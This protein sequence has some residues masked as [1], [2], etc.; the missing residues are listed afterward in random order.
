M[1]R[2]MHV[3]RVVCV[4]IVVLVLC[5]LDA[6]AQVTAKPHQLRLV[7]QTPFV[8]PSGTF[9]VQVDTGDLPT[10]TGLR[11][12]IYTEVTSRS[13]LDRTIAGEQLGSALFSTPKTAVGGTLPT[14]LS[15]PTAEQWPAPSGGTVLS[16]SGVYPVLI[17]ATDSKGATVDSIVT[18]LVRLPAITTATTPL[19]L[20]ATVTID[21]PLS[22]AD[23]GT[24]S[25]TAEHRTRA[26]EQF[27]VLSEASA[28]PL[29]LAAT[30]FLIQTLAETG[31]P[32]IRRPA[33]ERQTLS[34][35]FV[36][37]D[38]GSLEAAGR[39]TTIT[40]EYA[41]GD[42]VLS[43]IFES[44]PD[45]RILVLDSSV[46]PAALSRL[47]QLGTQAVVIQSSQIRSAVVS[48]GAAALTNRF[49]I[50]SENGT[51][52]SAIA[53][54]DVASSRFVF[55]EDSVLGAHHAIAELVMLHEEQPG[56]S[57]G[58][59][60]TIPA[61]TSVS[62]LSA[63]LSALQNVDG[64]SSGSTGSAVLQPVSLDGLFNQVAMATTNQRPIVRSW[65]SD[66]PDDLGEYAGLLE[67]AQWELIGLRSMLPTGADLIAPIEQ[68]VLASAE[69]SLEPA[70]RSAVLQQA[71]DQQRALT[72]SI[73]LPEDQKVTLTSSSGKI[74]LVL[75]NALPVEALVRITVTSPKLEFPNG[76]TYEIA[77][78]ASSTTRT[79]IEVTTKAS[80]AFPLDVAVASAGGGLPVTSSRI[81]VRSTA[82][83]GFGVFISVAAGV[84]LLIWWGRH[85]R[86][87]R[88]AR[89]LVTND[90][91]S[92]STSG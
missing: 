72:A 23:D 89:A 55:T 71:A 26:S 66:E 27:R 58:V 62:A 68:A 85:F 35:P 51:S 83:S 84:F 69:T 37:V 8:G 74:P 63:F 34:R 33:Q 4:V 17:E 5:P 7:Q 76:T 67:H 29:S 43:S 28:T 48:E 64:A 54:D 81:D 87:S 50:E 16:E 91:P 40:Q 12:V 73:S 2:L 42:A 19:S 61:T 3:L 39:G 52:F 92:P 13:R 75:T 70:L 14:A 22:V 1:N 24:P 90:E 21:A 11:L 36:A 88:R 46:T 86:H 31:D 10:T 65:T 20:A 78:A 57:R 38:A 30:P 6:S 41:V 45:S 25:V 60:L 49:L 79:D 80:G 32:S 15:L 59:A 82:I 44:T 47:A 56:P 77:L 9:T 53:N 18:H